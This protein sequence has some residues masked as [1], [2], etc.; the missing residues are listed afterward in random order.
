MRT[1]GA[2][3]YMANSLWTL[4]TTYCSFGL[5]QFGLGPPVSVKGTFNAKAENY[6]LDNSVLPTLRQQLENVFS[7]FS[8]IMPKRTE[9]G[10]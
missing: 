6:M 2:I 1:E 8:M 3:F 7:W 5:E 9:P 4:L 10:P